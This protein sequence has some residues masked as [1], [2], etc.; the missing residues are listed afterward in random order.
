MRFPKCFLRVFQR[1]YVGDRAPPVP[2]A[3]YRILSI[4]ALELNINR[5]AVLSPQ[6]KL[7]ELL[8]SSFERR[9]LVQKE[10]VLVSVR[11][12]MGKSLIDELRS[13]NTE[14]RSRGQIGL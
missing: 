8:R 3:L 4:E 11:D 13:R 5:C 1:G 10:I 12:E 6:K 7:A 14:Q 9:F 2:G